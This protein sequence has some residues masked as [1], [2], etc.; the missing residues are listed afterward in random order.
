MYGPYSAKLASDASDKDPKPVQSK[1]RTVGT[2]TPAGQP[3]NTRS[4]V[5]TVRAR[6]TKA[7]QRA[8]PRPSPTMP[9]VWPSTS[10]AAEAVATPTLNRNEPWTG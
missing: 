3:R 5:P 1:T 6:P 7:T 8:S 4:K 9:L 10:G 2:A